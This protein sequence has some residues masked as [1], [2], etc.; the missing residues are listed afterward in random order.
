MTVATVTSAEVNCASS[1]WDGVGDIETAWFT[2]NGIPG[3]VYVKD[4]GES[5]DLDLEVIINPILVDGEIDFDASDKYVLGQVDVT[6]GV[7]GHLNIDVVHSHFR[8]VGT[9]ATDPTSAFEAFF[10]RVK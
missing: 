7:G 8:L 9:G 6:L 5:F 10:W 3:T 2:T 4:N 1:G